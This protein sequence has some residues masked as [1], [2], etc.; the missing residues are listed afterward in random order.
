[1]VN[2]VRA[3]SELSNQEA[4]IAINTAVSG[5]VVLPP[6]EYLCGIQMPAAWT[7]ADITFQASYDGTTYY[8]LYDQDGNEIT[9]SAAASRF[10]ILNPDNFWGFHWLKVR[11]G[12]MGTPVNQAAARTVVLLTRAL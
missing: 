6:A 4:A 3:Y 2:L 7:T 5:A 11:S 8:D 12:T 9:I 1:M 10:I